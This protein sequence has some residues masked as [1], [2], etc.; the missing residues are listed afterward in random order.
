MARNK[1][2]PEPPREFSEFFR[3]RW[4]HGWIGGPPQI[5]A[6]DPLEGDSGSEVT[7]KG[8]N[9]QGAKVRFGD[10]SALILEAATDTLVV[11]VPAGPS[12]EVPITVENF[13][14][15]ATT[16]QPFLVPGAPSGFTFRGDAISFGGN[17][18][19]SIRPIGLNQPYLVLIVLPSDL[20]LPPGETAASL[21]DNLLSKLKPPPP[22][23]PLNS[24]N[25]FWWE[26][27]YQQTSFVFD[28]HTDV[29]GLPKTMASY[30][31]TARPKRIQGGRRFPSR[32]PPLRGLPFRETAA[33]PPPR[34]F[35]RGR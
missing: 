10:F 17:P 34:I 5:D 26:A 27:T 30:F 12:R 7:I 22:A 35:R 3:P 31:Q 29:V 9:L 2:L 16:A 23:S 13:F 20:S 25:D 14:G 6:F 8:Q 21:H 32:S 4:W 33:S 24:A 28:V 18:N 11:E 1:D 19:S 15:S